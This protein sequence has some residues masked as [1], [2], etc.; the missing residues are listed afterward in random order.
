MGE[1]NKFKNTFVFGYGKGVSSFLYR[2]PI[3]KEFTVIWIDLEDIV[4]CENPNIILTRRCF[5]KELK[6]KLNQFVLSYNAKLID[7]CNDEKFEEFLKEE[8]KKWQDH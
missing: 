3:A 4:G 6:R 1:I 5:S 8:S 7:G 2:N